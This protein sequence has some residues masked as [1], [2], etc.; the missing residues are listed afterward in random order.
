VD[1]SDAR[2]GQIIRDYGVRYV[3]YGPQERALGGFDPASSSLFERVFTSP[4]VQVY[5]VR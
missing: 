3:F 4:L 1:T 2:R 5:S